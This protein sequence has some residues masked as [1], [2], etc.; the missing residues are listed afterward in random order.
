[1]S[2]FGLAWRGIRQRPLS[3]VLTVISVALGVALV[4]AVMSIRHS[5]RRSFLEAARGYD[6]ILGPTHGSPLQTT[7]NTMFHIGE[8][9]GT[10]PWELFEQIKKDPRVV[11]AVPYAVGDSLRGAP[12]VATSRA[13]FDVLRDAKKVPLGDDVAG[14]LFEPGEFEA[15]LGATAASNTG[16]GLGS[17]FTVSHGIEFVTHEHTEV[18]TAVGVMRPTGTPADRAVFVPLDVFYKIGDHDAGAKALEARR[19]REREQAGKPKEDEA[20]KSSEETLGLS[21]IGIRLQSPY[22]RIA[23]AAEFQQDRDPVQAIK[24]LDQIQDL[25]TIVGS[26][27][28]AFELMAL[29]VV[30]VAGLGILVGLYNTIQ[31]RRREI[32]ILRALG[33]GVHH[34]FAVIVLE[35]LVL[36][37]MGGILGLLLGHGGVAAA[38]PTLLRRY[39]VRADPS[40]GMLDVYVLVGLAVLGF[41]VG[42]I[43][44][45]RGLKT[46]VA[47]NL[48]PQD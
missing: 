7:L 35:S 16:Y 27:D 45:I 31:G 17:K 24:P 25:L 10:I 14:R 43:P 12:V 32:A 23:Y 3:S 36:C 39:A 33:A 4:V 40:P 38:A 29:L 26:V 48:H 18:W 41:V 2:V 47:E 44:A 13:F 15:V 1:M 11:H 30:V 8:A 46:P 20:E 34:V 6:V 19:E 42:L 21:A 22:L 37:L 5:T 9:G 28:S